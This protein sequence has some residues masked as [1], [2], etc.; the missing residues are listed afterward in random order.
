[1]T[2]ACDAAAADEERAARMALCAAAEPGRP[3]LAA[4]VRLVGAIEVTSR[5]RRGDA[6]LDPDG[7]VARRLA[8]VDAGEVLEATERACA[9][10]LVPD[11][12]EWPAGLADL[13]GL[14]RDRRGDV[15]LGLW[16]RG[17]L[18]L[19]AL[20]P[21]LAVVG[22]RAATSYGTSVA[23]DWAAELAEG[24]RVVVSG[25]A[26]GI[27]AAAHRGALAVGAPTVAVLAGGVDCPYPRGNSALI[28]RIASHGLLVSEAAPGSSVNRGRFLSRNRMIAALTRGVLVV[29]A[30]QRSGALSTANWALDLL[31]PVAAVPGPVTSSMSAG[32]HRMVRDGAAVLVTAPDQVVELVG[33]YG[34]SLAPDA[35]PPSH[36]LD[37]LPPNLL[38]VR[39]AMPA[40][41]SVSVAELVAA[42]GSPVPV[43]VRALDALAGRGLVTGGGDAW[44]VRSPRRAGP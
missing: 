2:T 25:A 23:T 39:E 26:Y 36:A 21:S 20:G 22:S 30:G 38:A 1:M 43:V 5:L 15:P 27:D 12:P 44:A 34:E 17:T 7:S 40:R 14:V 28:D 4:A 16:V 24:G 13:A 33:A 32:P 37:D 19:R 18:P 41:G 35:V 6:R 9:R 29:E 31:R 8:H 10:F 3:Q 42:T 11:D